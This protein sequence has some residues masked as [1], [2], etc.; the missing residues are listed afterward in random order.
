MAVI[1][2]LL[3]R[4]RWRLLP[5]LGRARRRGVGRSRSSG[6]LD[7]NLSLVTI[8]GLPIL[9]GLGIDFAIQIHNR[10]EEEVVLDEA[11][12]P[13][14][15]TL[16]NL[17]PALIAAT[18]SGVRRVPR[19]AGVP[20]PDDPG[21]RRDAGDRHRRAGDRAASCMPTAAARHP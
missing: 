13:M 21:L 1:L 15:E 4:V 18:V 16:A 12:H 14:S 6:Y 9:I 5:L 10:V 7:V 11:E 17:A 2:L 20:G 3:F 19:A 8:S